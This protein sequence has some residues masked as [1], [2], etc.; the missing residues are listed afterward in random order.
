M[1]FTVNQPHH[2][3]DVSTNPEHNC[4]SIRGHYCLDT[5]E[6]SSVSEYLN[7]TMLNLSF[8]GL[9]T[10]CHPSVFFFLSL[11]FYQNIPRSAT[12]KLPD[13][14]ISNRDYKTTHRLLNSHVLIG[15]KQLPIKTSLLYLAKWFYSRLTAVQTNQNPMFPFLRLA[16]ADVFVVVLSYWFFLKINLDFGIAFQHSAFTSFI[17]K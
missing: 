16:T 2:A 14:E 6:Y 9:F 12:M 4:S 17:C 15:T 11:T 8:T 10:F 13:S 3:E 5:K 1:E 7:V